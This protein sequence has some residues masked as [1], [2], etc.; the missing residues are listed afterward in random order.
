MITPNEY[1][2]NIFCINLNRASDRWHSVSKRFNHHK[3]YVTRY[4]AIDKLD[5]DIQKNFN[6][7][8][9]KYPISKI[10][11]IGRYAIW[12]TYV[13]LFE[14]ILDTTMKQVL[15]FEDDVLFHKNF[16]N[17]FDEHVNKI[18]DWDMWYFAATQTNWNA[19]SFKNGFYR[20]T[21]NTYGAFAYSIKIDFL[22]TWFMEY[23]QGLMNNDHFL[24][25]KLI[26]NNIYVSM[27]NLCG[28]AYGYSFNADYDINEKVAQ[29]IPYFCYDR[30]LYF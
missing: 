10:K 27:P 3:L 19:V 12:R 11:T 15:I 30:N 21:K 9:K 23:K 1:F 16:D 26:K 6:D 8:K 17:M 28:H 4:E 13:K 14:Y 20:S 18:P 25:S 29:K 7:H 24:A 5:R 22:K 2:D